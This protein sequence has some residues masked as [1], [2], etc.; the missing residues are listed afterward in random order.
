VTLPD[1]TSVSASNVVEL[2][3]STVYTKFTTAQNAQR[4]QYLLD[5]AKAISHKLL[6]PGLDTAKL[7]KAAARAAGESRLL[8]WTSDTAVENEIADLP[9]AGV[10]PETDAPYFRLGLWNSTGSKL[11]FYIHAAVDWERT[12]CDA[13]RHVT[14]TVTLTNHAPPGL[15]RYVLG[16]TADPHF[17][18]PYADE[19]LG[20]VAYGTHGANLTS[21]TIDGKKGDYSFFGERGHPVWT[22]ATFVPP[23]KTVTIIYHTVEPAGSGAPVVPAQPMVNPM[24]VRVHDAP[25]K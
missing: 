24:T 21:M 23:G 7:V 13:K 1:G 18:I 3:Q 4:K 16:A 20:I 2:T 25:C 11:D 19:Y 6:T 17:H 12:G 14:V 15:P 5:I 22:E 10:E 9:L 8:F